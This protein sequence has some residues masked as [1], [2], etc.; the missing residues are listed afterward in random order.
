MKLLVSDFDGT[1]DSRN[2]K[3]AIDKNIEAIK[4][5]RDQGNIFAIATGRHY[6]SIRK[7]IEKY[8][9]PY[10]YLVCAD[11]ISTF[12]SDDKLLGFFPIHIETLIKIMEKLYELEFI[13]NIELINMY[14]NQTENYQDVCEI[15]IEVSFRNITDLKR[16]RKTLREL[17]TFRIFNIMRIKEIVDKTNGIEIIQ[18]K[19]GIDRTKI[20]T[21][22][23]EINDYQMLKRYNGYKMPLSNPMIQGH[24]IKLTPN[25]RALVR[26]L[27]GK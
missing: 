21:V 3:S 1:F 12:D 20:Y 9:I 15:Y 19:K 26:K 18:A 25:V 24:G 8:Q 11:G 14:G 22:G 5:F 27:E 7:K 17:S 13:K 10:D 4:R 6:E 2:S 16:F 23:N